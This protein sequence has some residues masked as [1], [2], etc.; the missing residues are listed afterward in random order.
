MEAEEQQQQA[1]AAGEEEGAQ[2][3]GEEEEAGGQ[4]RRHSPAAQRGRRV[5]THLF[6]FTH[7]KAPKVSFTQ[8]MVIREGPAESQLELVLNWF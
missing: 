4:E 6:S 1:A 3:E 7:R 2:E 5:R 8:L